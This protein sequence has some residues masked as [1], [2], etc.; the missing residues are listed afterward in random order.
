[1]SHC[2]V[3]D[4]MNVP[5]SSL[6]PECPNPLHQRCHSPQRDMDLHKSQVEPARPTALLVGAQASKT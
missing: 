3:L 1:M 5:V 6:F 4:P 2:E